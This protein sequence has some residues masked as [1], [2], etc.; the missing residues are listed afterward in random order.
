M[1]KNVIIDI[2]KIAKKVIPGVTDRQIETFVVLLNEDL[3]ITA[4]SMLESRTPY[5]ETVMEV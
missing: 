4:K 5:Y 2:E 3:A 1:K